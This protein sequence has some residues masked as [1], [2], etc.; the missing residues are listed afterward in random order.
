MKN[1]KNVD[2]VGRYI[3]EDKKIL[4]YY[5]R[6]P[7]R[8]IF[9]YNK[10]DFKIF[11]KKILNEKNSL[12]LLDLT[13]ESP[14]TENEDSWLTM[15]QIIEIF[16][17]ID[18]VKDYII[19][20]LS[21]F[22]R[23]FP[24][25]Q[26]IATMQSIFEIENSDK[27]QQ[28]RR[29]YLPFLGLKNKLESFFWQRYPRNTEWDPLWEVNGDLQRIKVYYFLN[30]CSEENI[31]TS[32][33][34]LLELWKRDL[35]QDNVVCNSKVLRHL[36]MNSC[37]DECYDFEYLEN[38]KDYLE[39]LKGIKVPIPYLEQ[40]ENFW[41]LLIEEFNK[42]KTDSFKDLAENY[43]NIRKIDE[44]DILILWY[45]QPND[46]G[47]WLTKWYFLNYSGINESYAKIIFKELKNYDQISIFNSYWF[48]IFELDLSKDFGA[49]RRE[50]LRE[51]YAHLN[52]SIPFEQDLKKKIEFIYEKSSDI[53]CEYLTG[54]SFVEKQFIIEHIDD[55]KNLQE[56]Y[57]EFYFYT[58]DADIE[59]EEKQKWITK[60]FKEYRK[61]KIK[62]NPSNEL[63]EIL[64]KIN[65]S[66]ETF[67]EWYYSF[68]KPEF[69][70]V[71]SKIFVIDALGFEFVPFIGNY[72]KQKGFI[73][74]VNVARA[75]LPTITEFN[76]IDNIELIRDLD[77]FIHSGYYKY[78]DT[79][80]KEIEIIKKIV[81]DL[82]I[83]ESEFI[84]TADHG[85]TSF[86]TKSLKGIKRYDIENISHEGRCAFL[87]LDSQFN[88]ETDFLRYET[89][90]NGEKKISLI[91]L[92]YVSLSEIPRR[93]SHGGATPEEILVPVI[94]VYKAQFDE[95]VEVIIE[96]PEIQVREPLLK[97]RIKPRI[98]LKPTVKYMNKQIET[99]YLEK[100]NL[101]VINLKGFK[102][103]EHKFLL[104]IGNTE[105]EIKIRI[106]GGMKEKDLL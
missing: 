24:N 90:I 22:L 58:N 34:Q 61:S 23:F 48:K 77:I 53:I 20:P 11:L 37:N 95:D 5:S 30:F 36:F 49:K 18:S 54:I 64:N 63:L 9:F 89:E 71:D 21:E 73:V 39:K 62:N 72:L 31:L 26:F 98:D 78:P 106:K 96:N 13:T 85:F 42:S 102:V 57:P 81:D 74:N 82:S 87:S 105:K 79:L 44:K 15:S 12:N 8:I 10:K 25:D 94:K 1:F 19:V 99:I 91:A 43:L 45:E 65:N 33:K 103:G 101:Y 4:G 100:E 41:Q 7:V 32:S 86:A 88:D 35:M 84:I 27:N 59:L 104:K 69:F 66:K 93:E 60:Y 16:K 67:F 29:I 50:T 80:I 68:K 51:F 56:L 6:Y 83:R 92:K 55:I 17:T 38:L 97:F 70:L 28:K 47:R 3:D 2:E 75:N 76:K 46:F 52:Y 40:E 14:F